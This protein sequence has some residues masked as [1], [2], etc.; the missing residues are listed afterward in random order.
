MLL[1]HISDTHFRSA[2]QKLY[3]F[4]D[5]NAGNA[6]VVSQLNA[7]RERPNAVIVSGDIVNSGLIEEYQVA[8]NLLGNLDY[9]LFIIPG[10]HDNK[11]NLLS[12]LH[13]LCPLL[14]DD[15]KQIHYAV[16]CFPT[17]LLFIDSS[18]DNSS[19]G[20]LSEDT[21]AWLKKELTENIKRS[22][23]IF[24]HHPPLA[25][26]NAQMDPIAC[27]NGHELLALVKDFPSLIRIFCGHNHNLTLT[28]YRQA[29]ITT[30]PATVHQVPYYHEDKR[31]YYDMS[32]AA[33]LMHR[34][35]GDQWIS[36]YHSL[37]HYPGPWVYSE[38]ISLSAK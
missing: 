15:P 26:G 29:L 36:Y 37:A 38:K 2:G 30:V 27:E 14:G 5:T 24:M 16:D 19:K 11:E 34:Q 18:V 31:P 25:L 17:R 1:A 3:G 8:H 32:P 20:W 12:A 13:T 23:A 4:I 33:C 28:Q 7:L 10:N 6:D 22:T 35:V 9:P 21:L